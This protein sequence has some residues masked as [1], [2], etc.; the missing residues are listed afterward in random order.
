MAQ[1]RKTEKGV[2]P[3]TVLVLGMTRKTQSDDLV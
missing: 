1:N 2:T 3:K